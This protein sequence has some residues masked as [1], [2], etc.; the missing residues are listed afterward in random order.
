MGA[1]HPSPERAMFVVLC[2]EDHPSEALR[3]LRAKA[4]EVYLTVGCPTKEVSE[5]DLWAVW[6]AP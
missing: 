4:T 3:S 1:G 6:N 2:M 5:A